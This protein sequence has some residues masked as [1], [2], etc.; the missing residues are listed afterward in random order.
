MR[1]SKGL[2][3][4]SSASTDGDGPSYGLAAALCSSAAIGYQGWLVL[5]SSSVV[6]R[7][8]IVAGGV[9]VESVIQASALE[10]A[11]LARISIRLAYSCSIVVVTCTVAWRLRNSISNAGLLA[12]KG[13]TS[14]CRACIAGD[15][16]SPP[17]FAAVTMTPSAS[18]SVPTFAPQA[19]SAWDSLRQE[20]TEEDIGKHLLN[21]RHRMARTLAVEAPIEA[22]LTFDGLQATVHGERGVYI[23]N[24]QSSRLLESTCSCLDY[25]RKGPLCKHAGAVLLA[26]VARRLPTTDLTAESPEGETAANR[27]SRSTGSVNSLGVALK[28]LRERELEVEQLKDRLKRVEIDLARAV[29]R[30]VEQKGV[31]VLGTFA[32]HVRRL[33]AISN[34]QQFVYIVAYTY[35]LDDVTQAL[36][37]VKRHRPNIDARVLLDKEQSLTGPT[38]NL[39]PRVLQLTTHAVPVRLY[40]RCRLHAKV[41]LTDAEQMWGSLNWTNASLNNVERCAFAHLLPEELSAEKAWY[42]DLWN[43]ARAFV[44]RESAESLITPPQPSKKGAT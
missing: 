18:P 39:R 12:V 44:G 15:G 34:A 27:T 17:R 24:G 30:P 4:G 43:N 3:K 5:D 36:I 11:L 21:T 22:T 8:A 33:S 1:L 19:S 32:A 7:E 25:G 40:S 10:T 37:K 14:Q 29:D 23:V 28:S 6:V 26:L 38:R 42:E 41:L 16:P 31:E 13:L 9:A 2:G 20:L 35:D